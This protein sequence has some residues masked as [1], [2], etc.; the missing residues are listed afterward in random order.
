M[1]QALEISPPQAEEVDGLA[2]LLGAALHFGPG[3]MRESIETLGTEHFRAVRLGGTMVAGPGLV[4]MGHWF[5]GCASPPQASPPSVWDQPI[6]AA[7]SAR[8]CCAV[9]WKNCMPRVYRSA[10]SGR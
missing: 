6:A 7:G 2:T 9:C 4:H 1:A 5:G 8:R 10:N 3:G